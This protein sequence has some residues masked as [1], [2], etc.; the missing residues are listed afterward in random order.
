MDPVS[1]AGLG[2]VV[3]QA[4]GHRRLGYR[5]AVVGAV[6]GALPDVDVLFS[7]GGDFVDQ[8]ITHRGITHSL[9]FAPVLGPLLGWLVWRWER[10]R[11]AR[12]GAGPAPPE[13][14]R[15]RLWMLVVTLA[16]LSHPLLDLLTPYG[17]QLLLPFSNMRFAINAMPIVDPVYTLVLLGGLLVAWRAGRKRSELATH[18]AAITLILSTAYLTY[19]W[20]QGL[21]AEAAARD[22]LARRGIVAD[23]L[24]AFP[25]I[26]QVHLRRIV[27]RTPT[28]DL[29]GLYSTWAPCE[30]AWH[31]APRSNPADYAAFLETRAGGVFDWFAM[32]WA[33]YRLEPTNAG[34]LLTVSDLRYG[35]DDDPLQSIFSLRVDLDAG[36][37]PAGG[38]QAGRS[39]PDDSGRAI[40]RLVAS[41]YAPA[42]R[43]TNPPS[44]PA[45]PD[46]PP[47]EESPH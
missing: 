2:A 29:V 28:E 19:G 24:S 6:A 16:L 21:S 14:E 10:S 7:V 26:F 20:Q 8:L 33:S 9:F 32:G 37:R 1:Q 31:S 12:S 18:S 47:V 27:A 38:I 40:D 44:L 13:P 39:M 41:T 15:C 4:V 22:Q 34:T 35:F 30:I 45:P 3:A 17:T 23:R 36:G 25:T 43:L 46:T 42:C 5:A 11:G